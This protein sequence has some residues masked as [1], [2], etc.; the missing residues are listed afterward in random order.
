MAQWVGALLGP[1]GQVCRGGPGRCGQGQIGTGVLGGDTEPGRVGVIFCWVGGW[2][3]LVHLSLCYCCF[4]FS[5]RFGKLSAVFF[6]ERWC[7][8][9]KLI[10]PSLRQF[11]KLPSGVTK[12]TVKKTL[13]QKPTTSVF[14]SCDNQSENS[15]Y[16]KLKVNLLEVE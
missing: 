11:P 3:P 8:F 2:A 10:S 4:H 7:F 1:L 13:S 14:Q 9:L 5:C 15:K 12:I 16:G 6:S